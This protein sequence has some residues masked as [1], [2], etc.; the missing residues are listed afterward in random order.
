M[1]DQGFNARNFRRIY[2]AENRK[3]RNLEERFCVTNPEF[4]LLKEMTTA[5]KD[6]KVELK[7][8]AVADK[9]GGTAES[10]EALSTARA[11][12]LSAIEEKET[13]LSRYLEDLARTISSA[14]H[15]LTLTP[16]AIPGGKTLYVSGGD[17]A[18]FFIEKQ[19]QYS[20]SR[21]YKV[22]PGNRD[23]II[24]Q[25]LSFCSGKLPLWGL[26]TDISDFYESVDHRRVLR[27]L[28]AD[29]LL[30]APSIRYI[31]QILF[32][33]SQITTQTVGLPRGNG[34]SAY[35]AELYMRPVDRAIKGMTDVLYY[36]RY[37]DDIVVLFA[38]SPAWTNT[39]R[40]TDIT[41]IVTAKGLALNPSKTTEISNTESTKS[42]FSYLGYAIKLIGGRCDVDISSEKK[43]RYKDRMDKAFDVYARA[44]ARKQK[45]AGRLLIRRIKYLT[46]NTRL[47]NNKSN[48]YIGTYYS[49]RYLTKTNEYAALDAALAHR[50]SS[51]PNGRVRVRLNA[52]SF[53]QGFDQQ[54]FVHF[55]QAELVEIVRIWKNA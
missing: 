55:S 36:G 43:Q 2:D 51:I 46:S 35:L 8:F 1:L 52:F 50:V 11:A 14:G 47:R 30:N 38:Q 45:E 22:N 16:K 15:T 32:A 33:Y 20:L 26:R 5:V 3:G 13:H 37:V 40:L 23:I 21:L 9:L 49:N 10:A 54:R 18:S 31:Q 39:D 27:Q 17:P 42:R 28:K 6:R 7:A 25:V 48:A 44:S 12:L 34:I 41:D 4:Q 29:Q 19:I 53:K 24:P